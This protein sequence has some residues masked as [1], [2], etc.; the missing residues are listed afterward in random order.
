M[1]LMTLPE[2]R[3]NVETDLEDD[4]LQRVMDGVEQDIDQ[5]FGAVASQ[6]DDLE[7]GL[8]SLF[9]TRP[10]SSITTIVETVGTTETTLAADDYK[11]RHN[12]QID[13]LNTGTNSRIRWGDRVEVTYV[14]VDDTDKRRL[15]YIRLIEL[16]IKYNA[17]GNERVGDY[18]SQSVDFTAEREKILGG[19]KRKGF[20]M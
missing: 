11:L 19:L 5:Q 15:V 17:L 2:V 9:A 13:R 20:F 16:A 6:V 7:G 14:P 3:Q 1:T 4:A 10:I 12:S 8:K 18:S